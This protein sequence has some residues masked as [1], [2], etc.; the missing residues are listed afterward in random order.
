MTQYSVPI[1][2]RIARRVMRPIFRSVFHILSEVKIIG[3]ENVP[4][5]GAYLITINHV[6][7][8]EPP[9]I[10]AF[11]PTP[12]EGAGAIEIWD[13]PVQGILVRLYHGIPVHRGEFDRQLLETMIAVLKS[14]RPLLLAPEG[15]R[16]HALGMRRALPGVAY[17]VDKTHVPVVPVGI[18]GTT[19]D[20]LTRAI[21]LKR[22]RLEMRIGKPF[23]LP[24][25]EGKGAAR[26]DALQAN[27][28]QIMG[29]IADLVPD[30]YR[31]VY[32]SSEKSE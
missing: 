25:V 18:I 11:W 29:A 27:A 2:N 13:R 23:Y 17:I 10:L 30:N 32:Q 26:R 31:G 5:S 19:D 21:H 14:G 1:T 3:R 20:F 6:S 15:G 16:T 9:F 24:L 12:P 7:L 4:K 8:F 28:D 22:P